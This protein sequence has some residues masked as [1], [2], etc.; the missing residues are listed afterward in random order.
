MY[1][2][3]VTNSNAIHI[4]L[5]QFRSSKYRIVRFVMGKNV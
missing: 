4:L 2:Q 3:G 1:L 5:L